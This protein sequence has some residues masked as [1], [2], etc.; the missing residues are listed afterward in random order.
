MSV[1]SMATSISWWRVHA[2]RG[3]ERLT[4]GVWGVGLLVVALWGAPDT[5]W[6]STQYLVRPQEST[7]KGTISYSLIG[8]Y[9]ASFDD[10]SGS[11]VMDDD[12]VEHNSVQLK[13]RVNSLH[14]KYPKLDRIVKSSRLLNASRFPW[15]T[16]DSQKV[17]KKGD[18]WW[19]DGIVNLRG[20]KRL[21][22]FPFKLEETK[23]TSE[24]RQLLRA[25]GSWV[26]QRKD[27][28]VIWNKILDHGGIIVGN[29]ITL[30]WSMVA[31]S[32]G[33]GHGQ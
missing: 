4:L 6:A 28:D 20:V 22:T 18:Q 31:L 5:V 15:I 30:D 17:Y 7:L 27:F 23:P 19:V 10:F 26:I 14:S 2:R 8:K 29:Q 16:F 11:I 25:S 32:E 1:R 3:A 13:V 12:D 9:V 24:K 21:L 33:K